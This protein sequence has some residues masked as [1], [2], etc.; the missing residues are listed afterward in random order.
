M[1]NITKIQD[2][3][4]LWENQACVTNSVSNQG[5]AFYSPRLEDWESHN[6][7]GTVCVL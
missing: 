2:Y 5:H 4:T 1:E 6:R 3:Q 7:T